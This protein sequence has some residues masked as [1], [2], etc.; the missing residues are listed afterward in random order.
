[1]ADREG[2][3]MPGPSARARRAEPYRLLVATLRFRIPDRSWIGPFS[4]RHPTL[5][6]E[7]LGRAETDPGYVI[8][9]I[10]I[11]GGSPGVRAREIERYEDVQRAECLAEVGNGYL[12]RIRFRAPP[13]VALYRSLEIPLPFPLRAKGGYIQW[14][15]VARPPAFDRILE[16]A[17]EADPAVRVTWTRRPPLLS[18]LP[19]LTESQR[20]LL[21]RAI[22]SGYF[23]V[24]RRVT[25]T[26]LARAS[27]R[28][29]SSVSD[30]LARIE[31]S[32]LE[33]TLRSGALKA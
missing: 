19:R 20:N 12:Y 23:A 25:L 7:I 16:F 18:H 6:L 13:I 9:D 29:K 17:R 10:W 21:H 4:R 26:E 27:N 11:S 32:L 5:S 31:E 33:S 24:P 28:S 22:E 2:T 8:A 15:V 14:E 30:A 1:M 3:R